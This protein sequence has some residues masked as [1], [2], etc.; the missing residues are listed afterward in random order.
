V[1]FL[2]ATGGSYSISKKICAVARLGLSKKD[3]ANRHYFNKEIKLQVTTGEV[4]CMT[5]TDDQTNGILCDDS[6]RIGNLLRSR[7]Y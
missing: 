6:K 3:N 1:S 2:I 4:L 7:I 5:P